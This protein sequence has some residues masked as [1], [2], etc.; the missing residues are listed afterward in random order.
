M[1]PLKEEKMQSLTPTTAGALLVVKPRATAALT[2]AL[3]QHVER[4]RAGQAVFLRGTPAGCT[5]LVAGC[6]QTAESVSKP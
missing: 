5:G 1:G 4:V 2:G 6:R 3:S